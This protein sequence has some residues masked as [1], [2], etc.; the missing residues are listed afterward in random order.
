MQ[1]VTLSPRARRALERMLAKSLRMA[2]AEKVGTPTDDQS[3]TCQSRTVSESASRRAASAQLITRAALAL[4]EIQSV[5]ATLDAIGQ[6]ARNTQEL[7]SLMD[8]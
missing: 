2:K 1:T 5:F 6:H 8:E 4:N 7:S 3:T